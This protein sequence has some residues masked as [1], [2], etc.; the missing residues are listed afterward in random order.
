MIIV[1]FASGGPAD[2]TQPDWRRY[3]TNDVNTAA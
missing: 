2:V 3:V 1:P